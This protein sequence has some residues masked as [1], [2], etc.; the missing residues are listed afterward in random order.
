MVLLRTL[1]F[2]SF[3]SPSVRKMASLSTP[4]IIPHLT[5]DVDFTL[6]DCSWVP[7]SSRF[8]A[9]GSKLD[10]RGVIGTYK[11]TSKEL[12]KEGEAV[13][14]SA[15][16]CG[17]FGATTLQERH[18]ATG[19]FD[20]N[21]AVWDLESLDKPVWSVS[22][23]KN[24]INAIDGVGGIGIGAGAPEICTA[25]RDGTVKVWDPRL[26]DKPVMVV[27]P[28]AAQDKRD[29]WAVAFGNAFSEADR[30]LVSGYENGDIKMLDMRARKC[31]WETKLSK[32]VCSLQFDRKDI[33]MNKLL[34]TCLEGRMHLWNMRTFNAKKGYAQLNEQHENAT[35]WKG[36]HLPQNRDVFMTT[37]GS[38]SLALWTYEYPEKA[39][40]ENDGEV[41]GVVG[42]IRMLQ[43]CQVG[44]QAVAG[45]SWSPDKPGL[46]LCTSF[47]QKIRTLI[48][49]KLNT[50]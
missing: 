43:E 5:A 3:Q 28:R 7:C 4:Q 46:G 26:R 42:N 27:E 30:V 41:E 11:M 49:T 25:S 31:R 22:A 32:G 8:V 29:A 9:I 14:K 35:I 24:V 17:T 33:E 10:G 48:V 34:A 15:V 50:L 44:E 13:T 6:F 2:L 16:R 12:I 20:G 39:K 23:H 36:C 21:L 47:D 1:F 45:F 18:L 37:A 19:D 40:I 38:G